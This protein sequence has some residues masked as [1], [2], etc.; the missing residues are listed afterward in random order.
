MNNVAER[1]TNTLGNSISNSNHKKVD[2]ADN[3]KELC[4]Y[5]SQTRNDNAHKVVHCYDEGGSEDSNVFA[6]YFNDFVDDIIDEYFNL[7]GT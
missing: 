7:G 3:T 1:Y 6:I 4:Q 5:M 2:D